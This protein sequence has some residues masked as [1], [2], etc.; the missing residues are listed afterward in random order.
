V[1]YE[2]SVDSIFTATAGV[3]QLAT[4]ENV[5]VRLQAQGQAPNFLGL[6]VL[7]FT[8]NPNGDMVGLVEDFRSECR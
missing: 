5:I 1:R 2:F 7:H 6:Q 4:T 8:V 3:V